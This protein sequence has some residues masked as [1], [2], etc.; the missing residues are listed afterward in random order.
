MHA[1]QTAEAATARAAT[2]ANA[3]FEATKGTSSTQGVQPSTYVDSN[4]S[5]GYFTSGFKT[6]VDNG[7]ALMEGVACTNNF[8]DRLASGK[9][10]LSGSTATVLLTLITGGADVTSSYSKVPQVTLQYINGDW[11]VSGYSCATNP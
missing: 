7:T 2:I 11:S 9:S 8:P 3:L 10:T 4:I 1:N 5:N 6:A